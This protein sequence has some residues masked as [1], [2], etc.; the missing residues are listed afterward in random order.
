MVNIFLKYSRLAHV[1]ICSKQTTLALSVNK[2]M[3]VFIELSKKQNGLTDSCRLF[4]K[5]MRSW[6]FAW[7]CVTV[8]VEFVNVC[9][10]WR[11]PRGGSSSWRWRRVLQQPCSPKHHWSPTGRSK[12]SHD[13]L[14]W[15]NLWHINTHTHKMWSHKPM[16]IARYTI[17][18][19]VLKQQ[20]LSCPCGGARHILLCCYPFVQPLICM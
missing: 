8:C 3:L 13:A 15:I 6:R 5:S 18:Q 1:V 12:A 16:K 11:W 7:F 19:D 20:Y 14:P 17:N 2:L 9:H 10:R 4:L